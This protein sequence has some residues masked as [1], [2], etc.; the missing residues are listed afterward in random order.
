MRIANLSGRLV[1]VDPDG[2]RAVD[3]AGASQGRFGPDPQ[4][5]YPRWREFCSWARDVDPAGGS[6]F[7][8]EDLGP[9]VP[10][11]RQ[12]FAIGLN[13]VAHAEEAKLPVPTAP[14]VF[15]KW[16]SCLTGPMSRVAIEPQG[17]TDWEVELVAVL[18]ADCYQVAEQ[19]AWERVAGLTAGQDL[20]DRALQ[21]AGATPQWSLGKS[22]PGYGPMGPWLVTADEFGS[23]P[24][25]QIGCTVN[26]EPVQTGRTDGMVFSI[27]SLIAHLSGRLPL[28]A[29]DVI[30]T[31]TPAGVG[32][33]R[34]PPWFLRP[35]DEL[36]SS[37]EG[38]GELRQ[39]FVAAG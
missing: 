18:G 11:P 35:G 22:L 34:T 27:P 13:Y 32:G 17:S 29:G 28:S 39:T 19:D 15:T 2:P 37:I 25:L 1:V 3:V 26:G 14:T 8:V 30:F 31:G 12:L 4:S 5:I 10:Q 6:V 16:G 21:L 24:A 20:S 23:H 38:I 7:D 33:A 9:P 36:V